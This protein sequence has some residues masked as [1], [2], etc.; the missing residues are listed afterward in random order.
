MIFID[1]YYICLLFGCMFVLENPVNKE[2]SSCWL[3][4]CLR[5]LEL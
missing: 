5:D 1:V 3:L 2:K 4:L